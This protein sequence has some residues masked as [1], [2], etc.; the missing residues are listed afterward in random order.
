ME[1]TSASRG[2]RLAL[3]LIVAMSVLGCARIDSGLAGVKWTWTGGTQPEVYGE[4]VHLMP[5]WNRMYIYDAR[6]QD[7]VENLHVL[8]SNGLSIG[9]EM[10]IRFRV[11]HG[12][13]AKLHATV[14]PGY[15]SKLVQPVVRS[16]AREVVA[17]YTPEEIYSTKRE[18]LGDAMEEAV[19]GGLVGRGIEI[20]A[21]LVR[22][23]ELPEKIK[24]AIA[25]KLEEEQKAQK[26]KYTL[27]RERKEA[28]RKG[29]EAKG[30]ADFQKIVSAGISDALL[31]WKGIEATQALA[32]S[33]NSK[34]VV[35][36]A[37]K[38]GLPIILGGDQ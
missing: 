24:N 35:I 27:A 1:R 6:T 37:G 9:L 18:E 23:V 11:V 25:E 3:G 17:R 30:I 5:P 36:G 28:E 29:I 22:N 33:P 26:M 12:E 8:A 7:Q 16:E 15:Y 14:G 13:L 21:V 34:V 32:M 10:S 4:G 31:R 38:G 19:R 2:W 20:E